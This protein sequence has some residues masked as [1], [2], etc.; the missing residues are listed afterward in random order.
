MTVVFTEK[1]SSYD[2]SDPVAWVSVGV[3]I[4]LIVMIINLYQRRPSARLNQ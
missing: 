4:I 1:H 3:N 2:W